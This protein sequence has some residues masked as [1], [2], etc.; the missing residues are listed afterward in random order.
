MGDNIHSGSIP[1]L[2]VAL[3]TQCTN[4]IEILEMYN[5][6][7]MSNEENVQ[8]TYTLSD[9]TKHERTYPSIIS[10][11]NS[12]KRLEKNI[13]SM[14]TVGIT[15]ASILLP[16]GS[17]RII[18]AKNYVSDIFELNNSQEIQQFRLAYEFNDVKPVI[19]FSFQVDQYTPVYNIHMKM[20]VLPHTSGNLDIQQTYFTSSV[21]YDNVIKTL[22][23]HNIAYKEI[24]TT[25]PTNPNYYKYEGNFDVISINKSGWYTLDKLYYTNNENLSHVDLRI[26]DKFVLSDQHRNTVFEISEIDHKT[27]SVKLQRIEGFGI[28][29]IGTDILKFM[30]D[31]RN[32]CEFSIP[33][34]IDQIFIPFFKI[35]TTNNL[36]NYKYGKSIWYVSNNM[37]SDEGKKLYWYITNKVISSEIS[38]EIQS[39]PPNPPVLVDDNF[40]IELI[41]KHKIDNIEKET[42][43]KYAEKESLKSKIQHI[44]QEISD[45]KTKYVASDITSKSSEITTQID[46]KY[47]ERKA[48]INDFS[49][50]VQDLNT[51]IN[52]TENYSPK[53]R[54][55]GFFDIPQAT[56]LDQNDQTLV[57]DII[58]FEC[59]YQYLNIND[60][61]PSIGVVSVT[62]RND[63]EKKIVYN[64]WQSMLLPQR[65]KIYN[66]ETN[67]YEYQT[68]DDLNVEQQKPNQVDIPISVNEAVQIRVRSI[69]EAGYPVSQTTSQWSNIITVKFNKQDQTFQNSMLSEISNDN[70]RK[71]IEAELTQI[72]VYTHVE[73]SFVSY[74]R[75][76]VH[77]AENIATNSFSNENKR[78]TVQQKLDNFEL[79][80]NKYNQLLGIIDITQPKF[81]L[82]DENKNVIVELNNSTNNIVNILDYKDIVTSAGEIVTKRY[83]ISVESKSGL[84]LNLLSYVPGNYNKPLPISLEDMYAHN[85]S[86]YQNY[87][88]YYDVPIAY[89]QYTE[90]GEENFLIDTLFGAYASR[91]KCGQS[92][93]FRYMDYNLSKSLYTNPNPTA[94]LSNAYYLPSPTA[95]VNAPMDFIQNLSTPTDN[96]GGG[97]H[98]SFCVHVDHPFFSGGANSI[99]QQTP[100]Q[101]FTSGDI[102]FLPNYLKYSDMVQHVPFYLPKQQMSYIKPDYTSVSGS[103]VPDVAIPTKTIN[104]YMQK[105]GFMENDKFLIGADTCGLFV[106]PSL[107]NMKTSSVDSNYYAN[108]LD[109]KQLLIPIDVQYRLT[110]A[111]QNT[112]KKGNIGGVASNR[113]IEYQKTIGFDVIQKSNNELYNIDITFVAKYLNN[114][115]TSTTSQNQVSVK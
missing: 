50:I 67:T 14:H 33:I 59:Q 42:K 96:S 70:F 5:Q 35:V 18:Y 52:Q 20:I 11:I 100:A 87:R 55:R 47:S 80:I 74:D 104:K 43:Q 10:M 58:Q 41:N 24:I 110:D 48:A 101:V 68:I 4:S 107:V 84:Q 95:G 53:Y 73:D 17:R 19:D 51:T 23:T 76:F 103:K 97:Q 64:S 63:V 81:V 44:D 3:V 12:I 106:I 86:Q 94:S 21:S 54:I 99:Y 112:S 77:L 75:K 65:V 8:I 90:L 69:S 109:T 105:L 34:D 72:G 45:L 98:T 22:N 114:V 30:S 26:S 39:I 88:K 62:D 13:E 32:I 16:D 29:S 36:S 40:T 37:L 31:Q 111:Y 78:L 93:Y 113:T 57:Q 38:A 60:E 102:T 71:I 25:I 79:Q 27:N 61:K 1:E 49:L 89:S 6:L 46:N 82:L 115:M 85:K 108:S 15:N 7:F 83:Y 66:P 92:F 2:L 28:I 91:Q 56:H 9:G